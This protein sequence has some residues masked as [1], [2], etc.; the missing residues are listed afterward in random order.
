M[1]NAKTFQ[2]WCKEILPIVTAVANGEVI[3]GRFT[4]DCSD[5]EDA[6]PDWEVLRMSCEYRIKPK[7]IRIGTIGVPR[8]ETHPLKNDTVYYVPNLL[9]V[10]HPSVQDWCGDNTDTTWL[11]AG[12]VHLSADNAILH[13]EAL[14]SI[15]SIK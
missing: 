2:E 9:A 10:M 5:W 12:L 8:P 1:N 6:Q 4:G 14:R 3:Q 13:A 11:A 15:T 7:T